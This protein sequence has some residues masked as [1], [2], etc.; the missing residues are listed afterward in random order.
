[1]AVAQ[2][3][4]VGILAHEDGTSE[5]VTISGMA[6][7]IAFYPGTPPPRP[8]PQ[9]PLGTW[10]GGNVPYP[11]HPIVIPEPPPAVTPPGEKPPPDGAAGW[12]FYDGRWG[13]FPAPSDAGPKT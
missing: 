12:G 9:P 7:S 4:V 6:S 10:G 1:M 3:T 13:Y 11:E 2:V 8:H 5:N